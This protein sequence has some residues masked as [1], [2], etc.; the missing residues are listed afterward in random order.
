[1]KTSN[2]GISLIKK[3]EG[4]RLEAY[5]DPV[6]VLTI[7]YGHTKRV[8]PRQIITE[9]EANNL[10]MEDIIDA[11]NAVNRLVKTSLTQSQFDA[12]VSFTFNLGAGNLSESTLL[13]RV[14]TDPTD[15]DIA[16]QF[17]RWNKGRING[18]P[19]PLDGL[20]KRRKEEAELYF[21]DIKK[22]I[23]QLYQEIKNRYS[24]ALQS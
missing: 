20:T 22:K 23:E 11:E 1:M 4:L 8:F 16:Y 24:L 14:N 19:V 3:H 10:L 5:T 7:G 13:K 15:E 9:Q 21:S 6:G 12:L 18:I 2:S 17:Q